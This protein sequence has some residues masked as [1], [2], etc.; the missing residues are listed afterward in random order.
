MKSIFR[1]R[2]QENL[3][4]NTKY[5]RY[6]FNDHFVLILLILVGY[7]AY[8]YSQNLNLILRFNPWLLK[9]LIGLTFLVQ[10]KSFNLVTLLKEPDQSFI[11]P[12]ISDLK[13]TFRFSTFY[14]LIL[15]TITFGLTTIALTP[16][17]HGLD[18]SFKIVSG[19][20][21]TLSLIFLE[22]A[23][24]A[25]FKLEI[26]SKKE[27]LSAKLAFN[28]I[29]IVVL[30]LIL[31]F[32]VYWGLG[33]SFI[34]WVGFCLRPKSKVLQVQMAIQSEL[35]RQGRVRKFY[36][37][38]V[39]LPDQIVPVRRR[40]FLD[41]LKSKKSFQENLF[42]VTFLRSGTYLGLFIRLLLI[43]SVVIFLLKGDLFSLVLSVVFLYLLMFQLIPIFKE[44]NDR[45]WFKIFPVLPNR[46]M[47]KFQIFLLKI[48][49]VYTV[50]IAGI[51]L[52]NNAMNALL[53]LGGGII[54]TI[55]FVKFYLVRRLKK[56]V[57]K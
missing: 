7:F 25:H 56:V 37:L 43:N 51:M 13:L 6:V 5:L 11:L 8:L 52:V 23:R 57:K 9:I 31:L 38:F 50:I 49:I 55:L 48:G 45:I 46:W 3:V 54:F 22:L 44:A 53:F 21:L 17:L 36:S 41:F 20:A 14:S 39:D 32:S 35:R 4:S 30:G 26:Y 29:L 2:F 33:I 28:G 34:I 24:F 47:E 19:L 16:I 42:L 1:K 12:V 18:S 40:K 15:P 27:S 10:L